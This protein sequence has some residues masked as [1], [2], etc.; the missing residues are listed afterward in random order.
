MSDLTEARQQK[1]RTVEKHILSHSNTFDSLA[2]FLIVI[3]SPPPPRA[4][5]LYC[6]RIVAKNAGN[7]VLGRHSYYYSGGIRSQATHAM[8]TTPVGLFMIPDLKKPSDFMTL[9]KQAIQNCDQVS[10][11]RIHALAPH[12]HTISICIPG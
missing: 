2:F 11:H 8:S 1:R 5:Q 9:A 12:T 4:M 7:T 10:V 3:S 6:R